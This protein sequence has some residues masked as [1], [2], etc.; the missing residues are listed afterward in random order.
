M[1]AVCEVSMGLL[2]LGIRSYIPFPQP[3]LSE[4]NGNRS[5]LA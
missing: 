3:L 4:V 1:K 5:P 2:K